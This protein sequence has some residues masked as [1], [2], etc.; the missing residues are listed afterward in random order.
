MTVPATGWR[1]GPLQRGLLIGATSGFFFGALALLDSGIPVVGA[2]VFVVTG[3]FLGVWTTRR[4]DRYWPGARDFTTAE[5]VRV[6]RAARR[7]DRVE[8]PRLARGVV[9]YAAG[10]RAAA[11]RLY[12]YRWVI[13]LVLVVAI[14][15]AVV[16]AVTGSVRE[17]VASCVYLGLLAIELAWWPA[18]RRELLL[19]SAL[20]TALAQQV[21]EEPSEDETS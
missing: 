6:V 2:I 1:G 12:P 10:L 15:T 5:R 18:R 19:N 8:D 14:G 9:D 17:T 11:E 4:M 20:A 13:V 21:L 3:G 16:D 7:G